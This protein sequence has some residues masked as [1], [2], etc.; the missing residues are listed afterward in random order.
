MQNTVP[1]IKLSILLRAV[2]GSAQ[3]FL[4]SQG[5]HPEISIALKLALHPKTTV[6]FRFKIISLIIIKF[7]KIM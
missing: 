5:I 7:I 2:K 3:L 1:S 6:Q 4:V